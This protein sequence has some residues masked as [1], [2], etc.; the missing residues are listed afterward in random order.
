MKSFN[1]LLTALLSILSI[2][3]MDLYAQ[4]S[5]N[6]K[7]N[8]STQYYGAKFDDADPQTGKAALKIYEDLRPEDSTEL[9][10]EA[11]VEAVCQ[12]KGC[13]MQVLLDGDKQARIT[14]KDYGFFVPMDI[15]GKEVTVRGIAQVVEVSE[16]EQKHYARDAGASEEEIS[17]I[18][19][20][21][22]TYSLVADGV[23]LK[24]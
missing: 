10:L 2:F 11:K 12:V 9:T 1:I 22:R 17:K 5:E 21:K 23:V 7:I 24:D 19:G 18:R 13:W 8:E 14:F 6:E 3:C 4:T 16:E 15:V 20:V